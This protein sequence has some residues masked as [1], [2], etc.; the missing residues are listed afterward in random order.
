M[1]MIGRTAAAALAAVGFLSIVPND[2]K[3]LVMLTADLTQDNCTGGCIQNNV[4]PYGAVTATQQNAGDD[5]LVSVQ[6]A[7]PYYFNVSNGLSAFVLSPVNGTIVAPITAG[8]TAGGA[9]QEDGFGNFTQSLTYA[10]APMAVQLLT[11]EI[12][13]ASGFLLSAGEFGLS[14]SPNHGNGGTGA[15][16]AADITNANGITGPVGALTLTAAVPEPSTW[17]MLLLGFAGVGFAA[18]RRKTGPAF[19]IA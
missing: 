1:K 8:F 16:F 18:Y 15:L 5:I 14:T 6:L 17:A 4:T 7:S 3:A 9:V 2:A 13:V 11:F 19:R 12:D 10:G